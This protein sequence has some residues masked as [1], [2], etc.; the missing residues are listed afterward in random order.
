[1][2]W[3][4]GLKMGSQPARLSSESVRRP[5]PILQVRRGTEFNKGGGESVFFLP[6]VRWNIAVHVLVQ[7]SSTFDRF[8]TLCS[9]F[10]PYL[11]GM[12]DMVVSW[13]YLV[14]KDRG[15]LTL[16]PSPS[17]DNGQERC[18][19]LPRRATYR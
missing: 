2:I 5:E 18:Q 3:H 12:S 9:L 15:K 7:Y 13:P 1:M 16:P 6:L 8:L 14:E 10:V 4:V 11:E 17:Q 19:T